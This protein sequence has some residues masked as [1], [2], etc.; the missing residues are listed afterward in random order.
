MSHLAGLEAGLSNGGLIARQPITRL[1]GVQGARVFKIPGVRRLIRTHGPNASFTKKSALQLIGR[2]D[3]ENPA[4]KFSDYERLFIEARSLN[5]ELSPQDV[6]AYLV[7]KGLF[8]IGADLT[9]PACRLP[10][11]TALDSLKQ[12][13]VCPLCGDEFDATRQLVGE[14]WSYRRSGILGLE[15]NNQGAV[16]VVLTLQQLDANNHGRAHL[17]SPSLGLKP[18]DGTAPFEVDFVWMTCGDARRKSK[19]ILGECKDRQ[20]DAIDETDIQNLRRAA[21]ALPRD[22]F[23]A[24]ILPAKLAPF[25]DHEIA[26]ARTLNSQYRRRVIMLTA[27]ELEPY[28]FFERTKKEFPTIKEH[29]SSPED[30][31]L[32]TA[33]IYFS[34]VE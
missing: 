11:W 6:F 13:I 31:A 2:R 12:R 20:E 16:A 23:D 21:D 26:L 1:D 27:R 24:F 22:R 17:Y 25:S 4:A 10:S 34:K 7:E 28:H 8:R 19:I 30:L 15:K 32:V 5:T 9:C 33:Q 18:K 3:P 14:H 29:G